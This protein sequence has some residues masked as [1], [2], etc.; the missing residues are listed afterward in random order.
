MG[1]VSVTVTPTVTLAA[2]TSDDVV[3]GLMAFKVAPTSGSGIIRSVLCTDAENQKEQYVLYLFDAAPVAIADAD[4]Y[5]PVIADLKKMVGTVTVA[6]GDYTTNNSL[7]W[8]LLGGH[9]DTAM[10]IY[11]TTESGN[12]YI[13]AVATDTP[14]YAAVDDISFTLIVEEL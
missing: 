10:E 8:A 12:V 2:Y 13:Y 5:A 3:G 9:E 6:T 4:P 11:F 7:A 14:D 1:L